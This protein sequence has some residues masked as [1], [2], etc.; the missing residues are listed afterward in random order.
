M[1]CFLQMNKC[2]YYHF[3]IIPTKNPQFKKNRISY[4][5]LPNQSSNLA[6]G[7]VKSSSPSQSSPCLN[8]GHSILSLISKNNLFTCFTDVGKYSVGRLRP[9][10]FDV[11]KPKYEK[12]VE[13]IFPNYITNYTCEGNPNIFPVSLQNPTILPNEFYTHSK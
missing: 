8:Q 9:H 13:D 7:G 11:C 4:S 12:P 6:P 1:I 5:A 3:L 10:F 2:Y